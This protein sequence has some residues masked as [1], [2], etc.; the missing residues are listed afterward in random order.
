MQIEDEAGELV[1][2]RTAAAMQEADAALMT[3][4]PPFW[5]ED[6][7]EAYREK[8]VRYLAQEAPDMAET[9]LVIASVLEHLFETVERR[10]LVLGVSKGEVARQLGMPTA[11]LSRYSKEEDA[12][13]PTRRILLKTLRW[14]AETYERVDDRPVA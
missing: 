10:R 8:A 7:W 3:E 13:E 14:V 2:A 1:L 6:T 5:R 4:V 12:P 11:Q 9:Y